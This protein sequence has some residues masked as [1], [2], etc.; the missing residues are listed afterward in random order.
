MLQSKLTLTLSRT[1]YHLSEWLGFGD[2]IIFI[3]NTRLSF[4]TFVDIIII[5]KI[6]EKYIDWRTY[7]ESQCSEKPKRFDN[8]EKD[9]DNSLRVNNFCHVFF[10]EFSVSFSSQFGEIN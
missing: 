4:L 7:D 6:S 5:F 8:N 2:L 3:I 9:K 1:S 10:I